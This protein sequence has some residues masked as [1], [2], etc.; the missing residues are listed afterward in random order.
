M[1]LL[2]ITCRWCGFEFT[3][4]RSCY[5]GHAYCC[6]LCRRL[7]RLFRHRTAQQTYRKTSEGRKAHCNA[8]S[9]RRQ[10]LKKNKKNM[11]D[12]G[13]TLLIVWCITQFIVTMMR[14]HA[15]KNS[16]G[17]RCCHFCGRIGQVVDRFPRRKYG[18]A[19]NF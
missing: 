12:R 2:S 16:S 15:N 1:L 13:S 4:C 7:S 5:R 11:D 3:L 9:R 8:E 18:R 6:D 19:G 17:D 14:S 10:R